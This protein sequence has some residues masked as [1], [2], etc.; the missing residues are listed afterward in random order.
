M[1]GSN[2]KIVTGKDMEDLERRVNH[3]LE[4]G[5]FLYNSIVP[6][7]VYKGGD[8]VKHYSQVMVKQ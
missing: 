5:W 7:D 8:M 3:W 4:K 2:Y 6:T 1:A